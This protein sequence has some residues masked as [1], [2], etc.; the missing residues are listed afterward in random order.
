M[1]STFQLNA[2]VMNGSLHRLG[3][4]ATGWWLC[5]SP[6]KQGCRCPFRL[7]P[8]PFLNFSPRLKPCQRVRTI[9]P[10]VLSR[11]LLRGLFLPFTR[12]LYIYAPFRAT[13]RLHQLKT[14][15]YYVWILFKSDP[16]VLGQD[17]PA[18]NCSEG[19][20]AGTLSCCEYGS[21]TVGARSWYEKSN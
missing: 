17:R 12:C 18:V 20:A 11:E 5:V 6:Q 7:P 2:E 13:R 9:F 10:T 8:C 15:M 1:M 19:G 21:Q 16:W 3:V 4:K 14:W